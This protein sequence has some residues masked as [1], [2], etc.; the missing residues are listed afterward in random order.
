MHILVY[1]RSS[2]ATV[3]KVIQILIVKMTKVSRLAGSSKFGITPIGGV[4]AGP[5]NSIWSCSGLKD[6]LGDVIIERSTRGWKKSLE[7]LE[8]DRSKD[9]FRMNWATAAMCSSTIIIDV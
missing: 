8:R 2:R 7:L 1:M 5:F 6:V 4:P 3:A 9:Q